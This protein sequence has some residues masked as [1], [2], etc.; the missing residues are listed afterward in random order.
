MSRKRTEINPVRG[1]RLRQLLSEQGVDQKDLAEEIGYT[2]EH[3]S[4]IING[5]RNLTEDAARAIVQMFPPTRFEWL[6]GYDGYK[7]ETEK[8]LSE[9]NDF[10]N[11]W[12]TRLRAVR[13]LAY[14]SGYN[15][16]LFSDE[17]NEHDVQT[18]LRAIKNGYKIIKDGVV[19]GFC[20][21]ERFNLLALDIQELT[22]QRIKS[23]LREV[24]ENG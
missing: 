15:I 13:V 10:N 9:F 19:V 11:E 24:S 20:P 22:E 14:L 21:L 12:K 16:E 5:K 8:M 7:T 3:I 2:K 18:V 1:E 6:M 4:Y 23:Y 17:E